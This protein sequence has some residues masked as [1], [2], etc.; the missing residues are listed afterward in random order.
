[1]RSSDRGPCR[2]GRPRS[3][4]GSGAA[5][6]KI[7][8]CWRVFGEGTRSQK[9]VWSAPTQSRAPW[10]RHRRRLLLAP[11]SSHR[12]RPSSDASRAARCVAC[13]GVRSQLVPVALVGE[14]SIPE[15]TATVG[16]RT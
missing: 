4:T 8:L 14:C 12:V 6:L 11:R 10:Y 15:L 13:H 5:T 3:T 2:G 1:A 9:R 7:V 16:L